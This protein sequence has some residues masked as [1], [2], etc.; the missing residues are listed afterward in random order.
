MYMTEPARVKVSVT[1]PS[2]LSS[3]KWKLPW[4]GTWSGLASQV[5][6]R[7]LPSR[8]TRQLASLWPVKSRLVKS[9]MKRWSP[10]VPLFTTLR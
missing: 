7:M 3:P 9:T 5:A 2:R 4:L 10:A 8:G 1:L 6:N